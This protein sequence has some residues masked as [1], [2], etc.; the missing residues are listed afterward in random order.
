MSRMVFRNAT[1]LDGNAPARAGTSLVVEGERIDEIAPDAAIRARPGDRVVDL[2]GR[3]LMPGM[4]SCHFHTVFSTWAP[5]AAPMLGLDAEPGLMTI[6]RSRPR[7]CAAS[8][9]AR[10]CGPARAR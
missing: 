8:S 6:T 2:A 3:T 7:S 10:E 1:L 5:G 4:W 9:R